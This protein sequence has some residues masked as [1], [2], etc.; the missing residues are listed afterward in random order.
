MS[1]EVGAVGVVVVVVSV[2]VVAVVVAMT[3]VSTT[4]IM[5]DGC[6]AASSSF[7]QLGFTF[8]VIMKWCIM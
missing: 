3:G 6:V 5:V 7:V 8:R 4:V 1:F 2:V